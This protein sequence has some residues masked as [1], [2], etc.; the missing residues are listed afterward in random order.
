MHEHRY[1]IMVSGGLGA[2]ARLAF[3]ELKVEPASSNTALVGDMDQ[4]GLYGA[5]HR[6]RALGIELVEVVRLPPN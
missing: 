2:I 1:R 4:A 5:L 3:E 6:I